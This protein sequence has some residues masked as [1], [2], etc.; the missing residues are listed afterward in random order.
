MIEDRAYGRRLEAGLPLIQNVTFETE[1]SGRQLPATRTGPNTWEVRFMANTESAG[2]QYLLLF[3][4]GR[5]LDSNPTII[6]IEPMDCP[7]LKR[8]S[9]G[10]THN[11]VIQPILFALIQLSELNPFQSSS[12]S[13]A[14]H[15]QVRV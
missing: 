5:F 11:T 7:K 13:N 4:D 2:P 14:T 12:P 8:G 10:G 6:N 9:L 15:R 1:D 3:A